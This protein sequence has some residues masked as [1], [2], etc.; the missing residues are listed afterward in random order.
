MQPS[1]FTVPNQW[2]YQNVE[3]ESCLTYWIILSEFI[4]NNFSIQYESGT[5]L[6]PPL[7]SHLVQSQILW[8]M[9]YLENISVCLSRLFINSRGHYLKAT[10]RLKDVLTHHVQLR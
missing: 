6:I 8:T 9:E 7:D 10:V 5:L 3:K 4:K 1:H 2:H